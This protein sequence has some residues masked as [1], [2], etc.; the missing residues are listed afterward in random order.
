[1]ADWGQ[2]QTIKVGSKRYVINPAT[3]RIDYTLT[4]AEEARQANL[5]RYKQIRDLYKDII[6]RYRPGGQFLTGARAELEAAKGRD[7]ASALAQSVRS[8]LYGTT[9][10]ATAAQTWE[11]EI[12][13]PQRMKLEDIAME[14]LSETQRG[15]AGAIERREDVYPSYT[16]LSELQRQAAARPTSTMPAGYTVFG[17]PFSTGLFGAYPF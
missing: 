11:R 6:A 10:P 9:I 4:A 14:R 1:M 17:Q 3:G 8:G 5:E 13:A 7:V 2:Y 16:L 12:G 15:L